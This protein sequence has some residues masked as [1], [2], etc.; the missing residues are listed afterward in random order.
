MS[1]T[2]TYKKLWKL[3]IDHNMTKTEL[4]D[5]SGISTASLAKLGKDENITTAVLIK[6][7]TALKCDVSDIMEIEEKL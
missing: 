4:R 6:I 7:C 5:M 2:I 3:L 1:K